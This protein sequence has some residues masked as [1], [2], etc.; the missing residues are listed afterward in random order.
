VSPATR[1]YLPYLSL[2]TA[3]FLWSSS[4]VAL[5]VAFRTYDPMFVIFGRLLVATLFILLVLKPLRN[6][7]YRKGDW[8]QLG[9]M[10]LC[11]PCLYFLFE[12]TALKYTSASQAGMITG[13]L[14]LFVAVVA[15]LV[16]KEQIG[17]R[18]VLGFLL[19]IVGI[20]MLSAGSEVTEN[21]PNPLL[22][23]FM[24]VMAMVMATGYI[25]TMK[26]LSER[27]SS[28]FLTTFQAVIGTLFYLPILFLPTTDLPT[29]VEPLPA[30]AVVYLGVFVTFGAYG[31]Y[32]FGVSK[33]PASRA[34]AFINLIPVFTLILGGL[35]LGDRLTAL[36]YLAVLLVLGGIWLSQ[37]KPKKAGLIP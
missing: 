28:L 8:K 15:W 11:E 23:N 29:T 16:L 22:G 4:F 19:A 31:A 12:A 7:H 26:G 6:L 32:N 5:K 37:L 2:V 27:Y 1:A 10:G 21:A 33:I 9:F 3:T 14:P 18:T 13:T 36:Q 35:F 34:T 30:F 24:E 17:S 25:V 20:V